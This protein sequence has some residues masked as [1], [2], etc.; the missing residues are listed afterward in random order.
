MNQLNLFELTKKTYRIEKPIR[1]IE[2]FAGI[3]A[4]AEALKR[5]QVS[6]ENYRVIEFDQHA[7]DSYNAIHGTQFNITDIT[8]ATAD[9]LQIVDKDHYE[10]I[11][12]YSFPCQ[13]LSKSGKG[14]GMRKGSGTRSGL[15]WE[16]E[17][18]LK[19]CS[20]LPQILLMENVPDVIGR[21]NI[22][23]FQQWLSVL[24]GLG[25]SNYIE[26]L[27]AKN[28]GIPQI[29]NR[30]FMVS[31]LGD[32]FYDF[33]KPIPLHLHLK[34]L[35]EEEVDKS[36]YLNREQLRKV[37]SGKFEQ[38]KR[39]ADI[40]GICYTLT[41]K[42][43]KIIGDAASNQYLRAEHILYEMPDMEEELSYKKGLAVNENT[44]KGYAVA[45]DGDGIYIDR[46][47]QKRGV[48]QKGMIQTLK[49]SSH[50]VAVVSEVNHGTAF[51]VRTLTA[52]EYWRLMGFD[53][54]AYEKAAKVN[55]RTQ[56]Y[57]QAGNSIVVDVLV[58][59]FRQLFL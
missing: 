37:L 58:A 23:D 9:D 21:K 11:V 31:I 32:Y 24:E 7:I 10:Y 50:D 19:E 27:N 1:L 36:Y 41:T 20:E 39:F 54:E 13:D 33:P 48:V 12:T 29:R 45:E 6:Y 4:Q 55:S 38:H 5:L 46:P 15:L 44:K 49:T 18:L 47:Y 34:D 42:P 35:L 30:S 2:L 8:K 22:K 26:C 52:K 28:F 3:G 56:L 16:V 51:Y 57:K 43:E 53:D 17:R 25:Y 59:I 14:R 40:D